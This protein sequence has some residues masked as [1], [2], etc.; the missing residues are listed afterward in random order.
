VLYW[1]KAKPLIYV[2]CVLTEFLNQQHRHRAISDF[3]TQF[4]NRNLRV[5]KILT[6]KRQHPG[7]HH[8]C[9]TNCDCKVFSLHARCIVNGQCITN[10]HVWTSF[11]GSSIIMMQTFVNASLRRRMC[12]CRSEFMEQIPTKRGEVSVAVMD[13]NDV[14]KAHGST[15]MVWFKRTWCLTCA[16]LTIRP[17]TIRCVDSGTCVVCGIKCTG[18]GSD[19]VI[20][21]SKLYDGTYECTT[22]MMYSTYSIFKFK[23][24]RSTNV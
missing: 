8:D 20:Q 11:H 9:T 13:D 22:R 5:W 19:R 1:Y 21:G 15:K 23:I 7:Q 12:L 17:S 3:L 4:L 6:E 10:R 24:S 18:E 14:C 16:S 2:F